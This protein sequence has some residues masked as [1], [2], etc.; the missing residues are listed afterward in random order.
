MKLTKEQIENS[1]PLEEHQPVSKQ[2]EI[3]YHQYYTL[4][5][6]WVGS[7]LWGAYPDPGGIIH[8]VPSQPD[9]DP[10]DVETQEGHLRSTQEVMNYHVVGK[11]EEC[12]HIEDFL[13]DDT[14]WALRYLIVDTKN[15]L[16]GRKVLISP[17]WLESVSWADRRVYVNLNQEEIKNSPEFNPSLP[18]NR[19]YESVLYDYY[20]R[21]YYW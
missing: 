21:P 7:E 10:N 19:Q 1:P 8:P 9:P 11:D 15:F 13:V 3:Q 12:G 5:Y 6:Y 2:Y 16:P 20:G 14:T 17:T 18:V 4:P